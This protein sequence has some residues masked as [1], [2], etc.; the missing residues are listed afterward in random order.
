LTVPDAAAAL[1]PLS[2]GSWVLLTLAD[3]AGVQHEIVKATASAGGGRIERLPGAGQDVRNSCHQMFSMIRLL[4]AS[5][6]NV[7][8]VSSTR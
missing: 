3:D 6:T 7:A 2:G 8:P 4:P 1:L 5:S